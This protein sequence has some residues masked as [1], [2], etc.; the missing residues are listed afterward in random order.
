MRASQ[1]LLLL[2]GLGLLLKPG[3]WPPPQPPSSWPS[4]GLHLLHVHLLTSCFHTMTHELMNQLES[5]GMQTCCHRVGLYSESYADHGR[6][7]KESFF[8]TFEYLTMYSI[9]IMSHTNIE[10]SETNFVMFL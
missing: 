4:N 2:A 7:N 5:C 10:K 1:V 8:E 6:L 9:K 3:C